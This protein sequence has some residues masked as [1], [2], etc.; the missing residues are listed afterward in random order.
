M[1]GAKW[2][3]TIINAI[4]L[5][6]AVSMIENLSMQISVRYSSTLPEIVIVWDSRYQ[7]YNDLRNILPFLHP[8]GT[9]PEGLCFEAINKLMV[10]SNAN[11]DSY[12]VN[13]SDGEPYYSGDGGSIRY[14]GNN[15]EDHTK[16]EV[17]KIRNSGIRVLSYFVSDDD[18]STS[19]PFKKMYG[20]DARFVNI[21]S[22]TEVVNTMNK[23]F[24]TKE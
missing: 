16:R 23:L 14:V 19:E 10:P 5:G 11:M 24:M 17:E 12:F 21:N 9:T 13:I 18:D 7:S 1:Q 6:K 4:A 20:K 2:T 3:K 8:N 15:A 22:L